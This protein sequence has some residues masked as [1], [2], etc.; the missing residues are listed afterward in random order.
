MQASKNN[1]GKNFAQ[2]AQKGLQSIGK[3]D[4]VKA[5]AQKRYANPRTPIGFGNAI[6]WQIL[7][8]F[9]VM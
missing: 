3:A 1:A 4:I 2:D 9:W 8:A 6:D 5:H 7:I